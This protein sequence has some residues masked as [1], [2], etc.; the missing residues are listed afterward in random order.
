MCGKYTLNHVTLIVT[1]KCSS[2]TGESLPGNA[3]NTSFTFQWI[4]DWPYVLLLTI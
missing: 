4:Y 3:C 2:P 1:C